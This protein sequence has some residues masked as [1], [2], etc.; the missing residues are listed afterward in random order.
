YTIMLLITPALTMRL[1]AEEQRTGTIELLLTSPV[2]D[3]ELVVGKFVAGLGLVASMLALTVFY[4]ILLS[5]YGSPDRAGIIGGYVGALLFGAAAVA[6]GLLTSALTSNQIVAAIL[7]FAIL[8]VL[9]AID[10]LGGLAGGTA[11]AVLSYVAMY[12]H[13]T[14]LSRGVINSQDV[15]YFLSITAAALFL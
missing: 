5:I 1:L 11:G 13:F 12:S 4:P 15:V 10:G 14:D 6:V 3:T 7:C 2:R 9:W 8:L